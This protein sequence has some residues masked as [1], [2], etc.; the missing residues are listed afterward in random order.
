MENNISYQ[1][2]LVFDRLLSLF[3]STLI[4]NANL[5]KRASHLVATSGAIIAF[6]GGAKALPGGTGASLS[7]ENVLLILMFGFGI[8][9]FHVAAAIWKPDGKKFPGTTDRTI[10]YNNYIAKS[11]DD[12]YNQALI[13]LGSSTDNAISINES[14][15][16]RVDQMIWILQL[17]VLALTLSV[18]WPLIKSIYAAMSCS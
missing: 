13:D 3:E 1:Q 17:Q 4:A 9:L 11:E 12:A 7:I 8:A 10:L 14:K 16:S 18:A 5:D 15:S 6:V 2:K